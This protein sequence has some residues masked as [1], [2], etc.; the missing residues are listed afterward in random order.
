MWFGR[1]AAHPGGLSFFL[2]GGV[3]MAASGANL[4]Y[5]TY[6]RILSLIL[7]KIGIKSPNGL[8]SPSGNRDDG[9]TFPRQVGLCVK[10]GAPASNTAADAPTGVG[11]LCHDSSNNDLYRCTAYTDG[12]TFTWSKIVD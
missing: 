9:T 5:G 11:D 12:T 4:Q 10:A 2:N 7:D 1:V 8:T 3:I 6:S